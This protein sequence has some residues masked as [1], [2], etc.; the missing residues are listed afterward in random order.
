MAYFDRQ[1]GWGPPIENINDAMRGI[2]S[3]E[4]DGM[5]RYNWAMGLAR[6]HALEFG[7]HSAVSIMDPIYIGKLLE[8][9]EVNIFHEPR[10]FEMIARYCLLNANEKDKVMHEM[11]KSLRL[12]LIRPQ[13]IIDEIEPAVRPN[14]K[15]RELLKEAY[16]WHLVPEE[17][18]KMRLD[19]PVRTR[20]RNPYIRIIS[21]GSHDM[22]TCNILELYDTKE[23]EWNRMKDI[24]IDRTHTSSIMVDCRVMIV[25]GKVDGKPSGRVQCYDVITATMLEEEPLLTPRYNASLVTMG[26]GFATV[27]YVLGGRNEDGC[28]DS[29]EKWDPDNRE[30]LYGKEME[31]KREEF[32][33]VAWDNRLWVAGGRCGDV[34]FETLEMFKPKKNKWKFRADMNQPRP[35]CKM[36]VA[37]Y[38]FYAMGGYT[39]GEGER[40]LFTLERYDPYEDKWTLLANMN[41]C[42]GPISVGAI[43][44][45]IIVFDGKPDEN[46][47]S[48][49]E[50]F[51]D[52]NYKWLNFDPFKHHRANAS[53]ITIPYFMNRMRLA[54]R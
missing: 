36:V 51:V 45:K 52:S 33:V 19:S 27:L 7:Q 6:Y 48:R 12:P 5:D 1:W 41:I 9:D 31:F 21:V 49:A 26:F 4:R 17:R 42:S 22:E 25:G 39:E 23:K 29:V 13:Y 16:R 50:Y 43:G 53:I 38:N 24:E 44:D 40:N 8:S 54:K 30:W 32:G 20:P 28:L 11:V 10:V 18:E 15:C 14:G 2:L 34:W 3:R 47:Q 37:G 46:G 35:Y